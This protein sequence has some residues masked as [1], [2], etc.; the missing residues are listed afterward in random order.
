MYFGVEHSF[1]VLTLLHLNSPCLFNSVLGGRGWGLQIIR[2][3]RASLS[4]K[5]S[6]VFSPVGDSK[7]NDP[8]SFQVLGIFAI[9]WAIISYLMPGA[10]SQ[11]GQ[12]FNCPV[13]PLELVNFPRKAAH[14]DGAA[15]GYSGFS[16][17]PSEYK[18]LQKVTVFS[19]ALR[20]PLLDRRGGSHLRIRKLSPMAAVAASFFSPCEYP[21]S[22]AIYE[23]LGLLP[24]HRT[25]GDTETQRRTCMVSMLY[26][27]GKEFFS[28]FHYQN[29]YY[30]IT[31]K[32][33]ITLT[34]TNLENTF[35]CEGRFIFTTLRRGMVQDINHFIGG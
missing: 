12:A 18:P 17:W 34:P 3:N 28:Y 7:R 25:D 13:V 6:A 24:P 11:Y 20:L 27:Y 35:T 33:W 19:L 32:T 8:R 23:C 22:H 4:H 14:W 10:V 29:H 16:R 26:P 5:L 9:D 2:A 21:E 1:S 31:Q 30:S 15:L